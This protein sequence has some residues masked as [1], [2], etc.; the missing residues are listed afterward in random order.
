MKKVNLDFFFQV[1]VLG[2]FVLLLWDSRH[3]PPESRDYPRLIG[4]ITLLL[5][6]VS[7]FRHFW[8]KGKEEERDAETNLRRKRFFQFSLIVVLAT[9]VGLLGVFILS[10]VCY[11]VAYAFLQRKSASLIKSL[12][13]GMALTVLFYITFGWFMN[14]PLIRGWLIRL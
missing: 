5:I 12:S 4:A 6:V 2:V 9:V 7:L 10:V 11:Y 13:I 14:V 1:G 3:Y 8:K